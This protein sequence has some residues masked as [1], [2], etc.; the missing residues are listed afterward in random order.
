[1][2]VLSNLAPERVFYYFEEICSIPHGSGNTKAISDYL[3]GFAREH[4][5]RFRQDELN[6]VIIWKDGQGEPV[7]L[8]G[9]MDMVC[10]KDADCDKDMAKEGLDLY[11]E[12]G[13]VKAKGTTLGGD[14]GIAVAMA[15]ALLESEDEKLPP[16]EVIITVDEEVG[17]LGAAAIDTSDIKGKTM[18]NI[19]SEV[20]GVFTVSCAGGVIARCMLPIEFLPTSVNGIYEINISGLTGGHSGVEIHK[21]RANAIKV[22]GLLL[23]IVRADNKLS[24]IEISGGAK[25][26]VIAGNA[27]ALIALSGDYSIE[28]ITAKL[29]GAIA[30]IKMS[31]A[32]SD[33]GMSITF[34]ENKYEEKP[35]YTCAIGYDFSDKIIDMLVKLPNGVQAMSKDI[36]GLVETSLNMGILGQY[37]S[38]EEDVVMLTFCV[39]SSIDD[40]KRKLMDRLSDTINEIGGRIEFEGD[41]PGWQYRKDSRLRDLVA[42]VFAMQYGREAKIEAI[43]AGVECGYFAEK[44][45]DLDCVSLG[46]NLSKIHTSEESMEIES[47]ERTYNLV[48]EVLHKLNY[49]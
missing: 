22:L 43:H 18:I 34:A 48:L 28:E 41:Y 14:D 10:D 19:D 17:M 29:R 21:N 24:I 32:E 16:L 9:H 2:R 46:P 15:L 27:K 6:N 40:E 49:N 13:F 26:N 23:D 4:G 44:I 47:V 30:S 33:P 7:I 1:M 3:T 37:S 25:D 11:I 36:E 5:L 20:E 31:F 35:F 42:G 8:Q 45:D 39:R 12:D 38:G